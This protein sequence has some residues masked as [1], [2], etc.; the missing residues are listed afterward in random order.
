M[1]SPSPARLL[2][3]P[4]SALALGCVTRGGYVPVGAG[5]ITTGDGGV[6]SAAPGAGTLPPTVT[7]PADLPEADLRIDYDLW[8]PRAMVVAWRVRCGE[9]VVD[10]AAGESFEDY[11]QRRLAELVAE[12]ERQRRNAAQVGALVGQA[13]LGQP[14]VA[15]AASTPGASATAGVTVDGAAVGAAA[16]AATVSMEVTLPPDDVGAGPRHG[17]ALLVA[18]PA[19][20]C[21]ME[22]V[23]PDD[24]DAATRA[25]IVGSFHVAR[26]DDPRRRRLLIADR[27]AIELRGSLR[28]SLV[29]SGADA[30]VERA[31]ARNE[32][33]AAA[34]LEERRLAL[35]AAAARN[36]AALAAADARHARALELHAQAEA[37]A[38]LQLQAVMDTRAGMVAYLGRCGGDPGRRARLAAEAEAR[39]AHAWS[40]A[41]D[42]RGQLT[43][44]LSTDVER[45]ARAR[46]ALTGQA[47]GVRGRLHASLVAAGADPTL[48]DR[49]LAEAAYEANQRAAAQAALDELARAEQ[50]RDLALGLPGPGAHATA[51]V[52]VRPPMPAL[53]IEDSGVP[54]GVGAVWVAGSWTWVGGRWLWTPG[55]WRWSP[56]EAGVTITIG[57]D[58]A[59]TT[60]PPRAPVR[61]HRASPAPAPPRAPAPAPARPRTRDHR[62]GH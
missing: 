28:A 21:A 27:G 54:P 23:P 1:P 60:T 62:D 45:W 13:V 58:H 3:L 7:V 33:R 53:V 14:T 20:T 9:V 39:E 22:V 56:V 59:P 52:E 11:R 37:R 6:A 18:V 41:I 17:N 26:R 35:E 19:G 12:R 30:D 15:V 40:V 24:V 8:L 25:A 61:D 57:G 4:L 29:A 36:E 55:A 31:R 38:R 10:G 32:A 46:A 48:R 34:R 44:R 16:G 49:L 2:V 43:A 47:L 51:V 50:E 5:R 42:L